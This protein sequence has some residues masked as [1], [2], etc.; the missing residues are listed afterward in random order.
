M[1]KNDDLVFQQVLNTKMFVRIKTIP[2]YSIWLFLP[3]VNP[4]DN[5]IASCKYQYISNII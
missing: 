4:D 3:L 2:L 5:K 1:Q